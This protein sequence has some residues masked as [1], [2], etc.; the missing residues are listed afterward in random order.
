MQPRTELWSF[1][2]RLKRLRIEK[3]LSGRQF[4]KLAGISHYTVSLW[5]NSRQMPPPQG[6]LMR[7]LAILEAPPYEYGNMIRLASLEILLRHGYK[8]ALS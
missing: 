2:Q 1:G 5:E 6:E 8:V 3:N 4:A 7:L